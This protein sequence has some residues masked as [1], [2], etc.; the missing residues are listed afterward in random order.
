[1]ISNDDKVKFKNIL[2]SKN[3]YALKALLDSIVANG[4]FTEDEVISMFLKLDIYDGSVSEKL[5]ERSFE[6]LSK[7]WTSSN[8]IGKLGEDVQ[9]TSDKGRD[10]AIRA[11]GAFEAVFGHPV[12]NFTELEYKFLYSNKAL[13]INTGNTNYFTLINE[14]REAIGKKAIRFTRNTD[15]SELPL[16]AYIYTELIESPEELAKLFLNAKRFV[17]KKFSYTIVAAALTMLYCGVDPKDICSVKEEQV[18]RKNRCILGTNGEVYHIP[19][20]LWEYLERILKENTPAYGMFLPSE[21][22]L[23]MYPTTIAKRPSNLDRQVSYNSVDSNIKNVRFE[24]ETHIAKGNIEEDSILYYKYIAVDNIYVSGIFNRAYSEGV[25]T[26]DEFKMY[27]MGSSNPTKRGLQ[28]INMR[29]TLYTQWLEM[30][31]K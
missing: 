11:C 27:V 17:A 26:S 3:E 15:Y 1:M 22:V 29:A 23:K 14:R 2:Y 28:K 21:Y 18:D 24:I 13:S 4:E 9:S 30:Y 25:R 20:I 10:A 19:T 16:P 8:V 12:E 7:Y 6:V 5:I 31:H